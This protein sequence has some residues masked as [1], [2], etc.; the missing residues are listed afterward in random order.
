M[1]NDEAIAARIEEYTALFDQQIEQAGDWSA[2]F[3]FPQPTTLIEH[4]ALRLF[5]EEVEIGTGL[6]PQVTYR[7]H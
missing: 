2:T 1:T 3:V 5:L 7:R 6:K 4:R